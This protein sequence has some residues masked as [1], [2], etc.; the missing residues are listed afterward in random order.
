MADAIYVNAGATGPNEAWLDALKVGGRLVFP[1]TGENGWGAMIR[2]TRSEGARWPVKH[3]SGA[4]FINLIGGR[5]AEAEAAVSA[6]L[7][8]S[9]ADAAQWLLRDDSSHGETVWLKGKGWR[10]TS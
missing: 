7:R 8:H 9:G 5:D 1:L 6:A 4:G 2:I 10:F 3:I